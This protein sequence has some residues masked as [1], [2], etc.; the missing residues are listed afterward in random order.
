[1]AR[2]KTLFALEEAGDVSLLSFLLQETFQGGFINL[3][4]LVSGGHT[5]KVHC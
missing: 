3:L 1:M 4:T 5:L 2:N